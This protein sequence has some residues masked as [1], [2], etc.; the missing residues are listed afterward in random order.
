M[1]STEHPM[2]LARFSELLDTYGT[3][4]AQWPEAERSAAEA[5]R[6]ANSDASRLF[7]EVTQLDGLLDAYEVAEIS[8]RL[9]ARVLEVPAV[10]ARGT[11]QFGWRLAWAVAFSCLIGVA[12]GALTA[13]E[14]AS[15]D[16]EW[17]EL[18]EVSFYADLDLSS[19]EEP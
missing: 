8:P 19:E 10:A 3:R 15:E 2:T 13:P 4:L 16:E 7:A 5:L 14:S 1:K 6:A 12:S 17:A 9:R 18:T 11:R